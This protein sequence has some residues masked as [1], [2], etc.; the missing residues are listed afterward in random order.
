MFWCYCRQLDKGR[1]VWIRECLQL[2]DS[3]TKRLRESKS[4]GRRFERCRCLLTSTCIRMRIKIPKVHWR[5]FSHDELIARDTTNLHVFWRK[6]QSLTDVDRP[7][8]P[9]D[10]AEYIIENLEAGLNSFR[11]VLVRTGHRRSRRVKRNWTVSSNFQS[12]IGY[13]RGSRRD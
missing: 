12:P 3:R 11:E 13:T 10:L 9:D 8:G 7:T 6:N 1:C 2:L 4:S 5:K